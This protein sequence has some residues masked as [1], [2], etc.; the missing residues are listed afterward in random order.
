MDIGPSTPTDA[1][2]W[3]EPAQARLASELCRLGALR[4]CAIGFP[5]SLRRD[6]RATEARRLLG[7]PPLIE[8]LRHALATTGAAA[9]IIL[10]PLGEEGERSGTA[11]SLLDDPA[12]LAACRERH[13]AVASIEPVPATLNDLAAGIDPNAPG[14]PAQLPLLVRSRAF[15]E[16]AE[17]LHLIGTLRTVFISM[18]TPAGEGSLAARLTDAM[19][20][21]RALLGEPDSIDCAVI[22]PGSAA[23]L[24]PAPAETLRRLRGDLSANLRFSGSTGPRAASIALSDRAGRWFRGV[25][26]LADQGCIRLTDDGIEVIG[27]AGGPID[28]PSSPALRPS[29]AQS[30]PLTSGAPIIAQALRRHLERAKAPAPE[31]IDMPSVLAMCEAALLSARTSQ[32]ESPE[33]MLRM[34]RV[35]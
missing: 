3:L 18:R 30:A 19:S 5:Q 10:T 27:P 6:E 8:D 7:D 12:G 21:V 4:P 23:G 25:T 1:I 11:T 34:A 33:M 22:P 28:Q 2:L 15:A 31:P 26:M 24:Y 16:A 20:A 29:A 14:A 9:A 32:N 17:A 35:A 13:L